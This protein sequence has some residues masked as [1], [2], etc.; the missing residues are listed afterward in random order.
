MRL[1]EQNIKLN[2]KNVDVQ[3][4]KKQS[5]HGLLFPDSIRGIIVGLS[6]LGKTNVMFNLITHT[7]ELK[8]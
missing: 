4:I 6:D 1:I 8:F 7:N 5:K 2:I 3:I